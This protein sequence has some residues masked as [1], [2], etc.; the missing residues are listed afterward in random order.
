[1]N[2][3]ATHIAVCDVNT[4]VPV[5]FVEKCYPLTTFF[6]AQVVED[7]PPHHKA[8]DMISVHHQRLHKIKTAAKEG[9]GE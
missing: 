7:V 6:T 2:P 4:P 1:M 5:R 9:G 3:L 8:G